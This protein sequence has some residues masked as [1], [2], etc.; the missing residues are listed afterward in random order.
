M[1]EQMR[2]FVTFIFSWV[3]HALSFIWV[4]SYLSGAVIFS[5]L[6]WVILSLRA[7]FTAS[8]VA[9]WSSSS[10]TLS[11]VAVVAAAS[12]TSF[13]GGVMFSDSCMLDSHAG[14]RD[15]DQLL[16]ALIILKADS[17]SR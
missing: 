10:L 8:R 17:G 16:D 7:A 3:F 13:S 11:G 12:A 2:M 14:M 6:L 9:T 1:R 4:L 5:A 15:L